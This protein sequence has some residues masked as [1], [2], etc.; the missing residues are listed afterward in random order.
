MSTKKVSFTWSKEGESFSKEVYGIWTKTAPTLSPPSPAS[1]ET[2]LWIAEARN[3]EL[4]FSPAPSQKAFFQEYQDFISSHPAPAT[5]CQGEIPGKC[6]LEVGVPFYPAPTHGRRVYLGRSM[7]RTL[8]PWL[9]FPHAM[10]G[11]P[12]GPQVTATPHPHWAL[13]S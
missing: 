2:P 5:C 8:G 4:S 3:T 11:K 6:S 12:R 9:P 13:T 7:L 10:K 1:L